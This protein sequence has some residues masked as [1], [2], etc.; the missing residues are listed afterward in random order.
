MSADPRF[1]PLDLGIR[2]N[3][4][5]QGFLAFERAASAS[6]ARVES[7]ARKF[8][9]SFEEVGRVISNALAGGGNGSAR[10]DLG[11]GQFRQAA[12]EAR[13]HEAALQELQRATAALIIRLSALKSWRRDRLL[14]KPRR[15]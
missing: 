2:F 8:T 1:P 14:P 4:D 13:L 6:F 7:R 9:A 3:D 5:G 12:A 15:R 11:L 10:L